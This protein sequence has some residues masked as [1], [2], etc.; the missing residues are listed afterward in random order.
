V[1]HN[2]LLTVVVV[3]A[4][5]ATAV[6]FGTVSAQPRL[7]GLFWA[8]AASVPFILLREFGRRFEM[9]HLNLGRATVLDGTVAAVQTLAI[10]WLGASGLLSGANAFLAI[11]FAWAV[12]A[13][14]FLYSTR[15]SYVFSREDTRRWLAHDFSYGKWVFAARVTTHLRVALVP[16]MISY[17]LGDAAT[18]SFA[19]CYN[20]SFFIA[21]LVLA[22][23]NIAAPEASSSYTE[24]GIPGLRRFAVRTTLFAGAVT[25]GLSLLII[26]FGDE[27]VQYLYG[28]EFP[29]LK[30]AVALLCLAVVGQAVAIAPTNGLFAIRR[31]DVNFA[32][33]LL[34][35]C[36]TIC[37]VPYWIPTW[38]VVG[39]AGAFG[40]GVAA[41]TITKTLAFWWCLGRRPPGPNP[42]TPTR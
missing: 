29:P 8:L 28:S 34:G 15:R 25:L 19:A 24:H 18:G 38:S 37:V 3:A 27:L 33:N 39:A 14:L 9:A 22:M 6:M 23:S 42:I 5:V 31:P 35:L 36:A 26:P 11:G 16:W 2:A 32:G 1:I 4:F 40:I 12:G 21:P 20:I 30:A 7:G 13:T 41:E 10:L 17:L